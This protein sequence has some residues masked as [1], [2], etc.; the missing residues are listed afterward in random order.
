MA[1]AVFIRINTA[2]NEYLVRLICAKTKV[3]PLKR[4]TI[5]RLE[6]SAA[7]LLARLVVHVQNTLD[8]LEA[9]LFLWTDSSV[10]LTWLTTHPSRWKDFVRNRV[11]AI[12]ELLPNSSWHFISGKENPADCAS[13]GLRPSQLATHNLWWNG[14]EW[15]RGPTTTWP[16]AAAFSSPD[17]DNEMRPNQATI[18]VVQPASYWDLLDKHSSLIKLLRI[19]ALCRRFISRL[20]QTAN[21]SIAAPLTPEE[22][23]QARLFW[24]KVVQQS[25]FLNEIRILTQG[26]VLPRSNALV[27]LIP[28]IDRE[29]ILRVGGRLHHAKIDVESKHPIILP[30]RSPLTSLVIKDAHSRTLHGGTKEHIL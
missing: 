23:C 20:K 9:P 30:R 6:L 5:P 29:G 19:T 22:I 26:E 18:A 15:L 28:F 4:I 3:A 17:A 11:Y 24:S 16:T 1:A 25:W 8:L 13:R 10:A 2:G 21:V 14:P 27:R 7:L 12:Q